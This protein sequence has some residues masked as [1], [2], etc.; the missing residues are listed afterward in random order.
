MGAGASSGASP[1][2]IKACTALFKE[3]RTEYEKMLSDN[4]DPE[5]IVKFINGCHKRLEDCAK[6]SIS[7]NEI[8]KAK[9]VHK[10][11]ANIRGQIKRGQSTSNVGKSKNRRR[12]YGNADVDKLNKIAGGAGLEGGLVE[13]ASAPALDNVEAAA[14]A[15]LADAEKQ[16][17]AMKAMNASNGSPQKVNG[18][19]DV[20]DH[21]DSVREMPYC[22]DCQMA[23]KTMSALTR[24]VKYS[25]LHETTLKKKEAAAVA[26]Q[27]TAVGDG[28]SENTGELKVSAKVL[29]ARQEEG[30]DFRLLYTGSKFFWRTQDNIDLSFYLHLLLHTIEIIPF[31]VHKNREM[32]R[33]YLDKYVL[34]TA[35]DEEVKKVTA[36]KKQDLYDT[37]AKS[38]FTVDI[39]FDDDIE[40]LSMQR[41]MCT[42]YILARLS[43]VEV[44]G[45]KKH[46]HTISFHTL[47]SDDQKYDPLLTVIPEALVPVSVTHRRNSSS[48]EIKSKLEEVSISQNE[49]R[50]SIGKAEKV[51]SMVNSFIR[52]TSQSKFLSSLSLP[53]KRFVMAVKKVM[54]IIGVE[55]TKKHLAALESKNISMGLPPTGSPKTDRRA[56]QAR[57]RHE[58]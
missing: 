19:G 27:A 42:Q 25:N 2:A 48:E 46:Q 52:M 12:S 24:H 6:S 51:S 49:L 21:W 43:L 1:S 37:A 17:E 50:A 58:I 29:L 7:L 14:S 23:F 56:R 39:K 38:K 36:K 30:K 40:Y 20:T 13:S 11:H 15:A 8:T 5:I 31:D 32:T 22:E 26:E 55:K 45:G 44:E 18:E 53:K 16:L 34:D 54:Q 35:Q 41:I 33:I 4:A 10:P 28:A 9:A 57:R 3:M 47:A